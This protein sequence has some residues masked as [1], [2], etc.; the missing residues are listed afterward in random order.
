MYHLF[1]REQFRVVSRRLGWANA[2]ET[3]EQVLH[4]LAPALQD[5]ARRHGFDRLAM[6]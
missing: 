1:L 6:D 4:Q 5:V 3:F 2:R